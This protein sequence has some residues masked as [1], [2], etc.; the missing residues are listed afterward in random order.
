MKKELIEQV[1]KTIENCLRTKFRDY[2]PKNNYMPFHYRLLGSDRLALYSFIHSL[3]T[4]FGSSVFEPVAVSL[5]KDRFKFADSQHTVG[6]ELFS[7]CS[8]AIENIMNELEISRRKPDRTDEL[9][10]LRSSLSGVKNKKKPT[11][12]DLFLIDKN[13]TLWI[14]DMKSPKPNIGEFK[15]FKRTLLTW[16]GVAMTENPDVSVNALIAIT[17]NP[18]YP[19]PY[20]SWQMRGMLEQDEVLVEKE[21]WDFL[22]GE[23]AYEQLLDCFAHVG[24]KMRDEI[25]EYFQRFKTIR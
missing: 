6:K 3:N 11:K 13:D 4:T 7:D 8:D 16:S 21:F 20:E 17:Y 12:A 5:A 23:G 22:G 24:T 19:Q 10:I 18:N 15:G 1:E 9:R 25:D 2:I 14:F